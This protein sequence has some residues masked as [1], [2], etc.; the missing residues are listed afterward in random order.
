M[1]MN[2]ER[3]VSPKSLLGFYV[4][5]QYKVAHN[6][7]FSTSEIYKIM[8]QCKYFYRTTSAAVRAVKSGFWDFVQFF[9]KKYL[10]LSQVR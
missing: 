5:V 9:L 10:Y 8:A 6:G 2:F 1:T 7:D 3:D 4:T